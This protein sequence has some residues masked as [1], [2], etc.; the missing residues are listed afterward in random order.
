MILGLTSDQEFFKETTARFLDEFA[1]V[2]TLRSLR[3]DPVGYDPDVWRRGAE[4]GWT[5]FLV[6]DDAGG[7]SIS[8]SGLHDLV[9]VADEFGRHAAPG[10]LVATNI[11]AGTL[12]DTGVRPD[13]VAGLLDGS[14]TATWCTGES[15]RFGVLSVDI[16]PD[17]DGAIVSGVCRPV[18]AAASAQHFLVTGASGAGRSQVLIPADAEGV[19]VE[20]LT[21]VDL[22]RRFGIVRF[23]NVRVPAE[24]IV[25]ALGDADE[26]VERQLDRALVLLAAESAGAMQVAFDMTVEW[27][28][29]RYSFGRPLASYQALKHRFAHMKSWLEGSFAIGADAASGVADGRV[30]GPILASA[31]S[32]FIGDY[33][34][35]LM[36]DCVQIHGGIGVTFEHD[37]HLYLRRHTVNRAQF[38]SPSEHRLR[39]VDI[40]EKIEKA[41]A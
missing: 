14:S 39:I 8:G 27:A 17:G 34:S 23:A 32:S 25:G 30:D 18:E 35:E 26:Q 31:A 13:V 16:S 22:T 4:L 5:S 9:L 19:S 36:Q 3:H 29:D 1:P 2:T 7:G 12:S 15:G 20:P 21:S 11:V 33:G 41:A 37:L 38:G 10:P 28:F 24:S 40:S 6:S